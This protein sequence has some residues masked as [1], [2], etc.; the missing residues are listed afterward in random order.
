MSVLDRAK[1]RINLMFDKFDNLGIAV[2]GGKDSLVLAHLVSNIAKKRNR[3]LVMHNF[4]SEFVFDETIKQI[5]YTFNMYNT[6]T[7]MFQLQCSVKNNFNALPITQ[8]DCSKQLVQP[9]HKQAIIKLPDIDASESYN[10]LLRSTY[11]YTNTQA[12]FI[13][14]RAEESPQRRFATQTN[15]SKRTG[16]TWVTDKHNHLNIYPI[17][18]WS[19]MDIF[20]YIIDNKLKYHKWYDFYYKKYGNLKSRVSTFL[21]SK[22]F[23]EIQDIAEFEPDTFNRLCNRLPFINIFYDFNLSK[24]EINRLPPQFNTWHEYRLFLNTTDKRNDKT[25]KYQYHDERLNKIICKALLLNDIKHLPEYINALKLQSKQ[26]RD[27][28]ILEL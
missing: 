23:R 27:W 2:S 14:I 24:E 26:T 17:Y 7:F 21:N 1:E 8:F 12:S 16:Y 6:S 4:G 3:A 5:E 19:T 18:D 10:K 9:I 15:I 13:G 11:K 22:S 28:S 25:D 20:K